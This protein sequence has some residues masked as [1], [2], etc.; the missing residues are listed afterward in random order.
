M[1]STGAPP[2]AGQVIVSTERKFWWDMPA[3][4]IHH[5]AMEA[6]M[7]H[8]TPT[9]TLGTTAANLPGAIAATGEK[10]CLRPRGL[11][12][13]RR[14]SQLSLLFV[15]HDCIMSTSAPPALPGQ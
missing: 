14:P 3:R 10:Y 4:P 15:G 9:P 12:P 6:H 7:H 13:S 11:S 5:K 1:R 2:T 8:H